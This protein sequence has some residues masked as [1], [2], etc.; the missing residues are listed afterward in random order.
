[1]ELYL[2]TGD[3]YK[4]CRQTRRLALIRFQVVLRLVPPYL[5]VLWPSD[6]T[7]MDIQDISPRFCGNLNTFHG[8]SYSGN[9]GEKRPEDVSRLCSYGFRIA[10]FRNFRNS[11]V[12][13][14]LHNFRTRE[15]SV[16]STRKTASNLIHGFSA[17]KVSR[18]LFPPLVGVC[19][20]CPLY[21]K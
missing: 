21:Q 8:I 7:A 16:R 12:F 10:H 1:M 20:L 3:Q 11:R 2:Y 6:I 14:K 4:F 9:W 17:T 19:S 5:G 13:M 15:F 18:C